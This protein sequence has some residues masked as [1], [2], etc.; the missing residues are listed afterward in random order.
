[1]LGPAPDLLRAPLEPPLLDMLWGIYFA[2]GDEHA[3]RRLIG[4]LDLLEDSGAAARFAT[5]ARTDADRQRA[6]ND[7]MLQ[8][9]SASLRSVMQMHAPLFAMCERIFETAKLRPNERIALVLQLQAVAPAR[10]DV[11]IDPASGTATVNKR[12]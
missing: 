2:T 3:V 8:A 1:M 7:A 10:W 9:A 4:A 5:S 11:K 6:I 12:R